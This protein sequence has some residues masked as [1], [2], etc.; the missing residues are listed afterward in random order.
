MSSPASPH[1]QKP[2]LFALGLDPNWGLYAPALLELAR[3]EG[4]GIHI[5]ETGAPLGTGTFTSSSVMNEQDAGANPAAPVVHMD[6]PEGMKDFGDP[7]PDE[8][9]TPNPI[10]ESKPVQAGDSTLAWPDTVIANARMSDFVQDLVQYF[11][12][13]GFTAAGEWRP[14]FEM[15]HLKDYARHIGAD[16]VALPKVGFPANLIQNAVVNS[17]HEAGLRVELL[18]EASG[19]E[20]EALEEQNAARGIDDSA[21]DRSVVSMN[22]A[23]AG[24]EPLEALIGRRS[25]VNVPALDGS[26]LILEGGIVDATILE[27]ARADNMVEALV[28]AVEEI[29]SRD[30]QT[31]TEKSKQEERRPDLE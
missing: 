28:S 21:A 31:L 25:R 12:D 18:H 3:R 1:P 9:P 27:R 10:E 26:M 14:D 29:S 17:L 19:P 30:G 16:L 8:L 6:L 24:Q 5:L 20:I 2:L 15:G 4:R 22:A 13:A 23:K 11:K 7:H